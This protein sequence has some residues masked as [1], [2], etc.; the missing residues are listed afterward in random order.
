MNRDQLR[1]MG[2]E[3]LDAVEWLEHHTTTRT[4]KRKDID[5][6]ESHL[7]HLRRTAAK[8]ID[9]T[10]RNINDDLTVEEVDDLV[11]SSPLPTDPP[12]SQ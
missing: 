1:R 6:M 11:E 10:I 4:T 7:Y 5:A 2:H 3:M 9:T 8:L 12:S